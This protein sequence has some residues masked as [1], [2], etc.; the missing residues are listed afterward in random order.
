M[1]GAAAVSRTAAAV[2]CAIIAV[3]AQANAPSSAAELVQR[4]G[5]L[6]PL[7]VVLQDETGRERPL[8]HYFGRVPVVL[9]FGYYRCPTLCTTLMEGVLLGVSATG[10]PDNAYEIIGVSIDPRERPE[11]AA[12]KAALSRSV[13]ERAPLHLL[14]ATAPASS[15]LARAAGF[16]YAYDSR[17]DQYSHPLAFLILTPDGHVSRYFPGVRFEPR[18][19][20][21]ALIEASGER[22]GSLSDR[23]FLRCAHYDPAA[24]RY[25]VAVMAFVRG[26]SVL[27]IAALALWMWRQRK[28]S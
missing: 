11:D 6:L 13:H 17:F 8:S 3:H 15:E 1:I 16:R 14:T 24:G 22:I 9:V 2:L 4:P 18:D 7:D 26:A 25:N 23:I 27:L 28:S 12:R 21:L 20:R 5:A 10:L 19:V